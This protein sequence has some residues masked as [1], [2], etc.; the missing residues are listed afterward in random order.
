MTDTI[1]TMMHVMYRVRKT[2]QRERRVYQRAL[3]VRVGL[4][5]GLTE[6][7]FANCVGLLATHGWLTIDQGDRGKPI[8]IFNDQYANVSVRPPEEVI[9]HAEQCPPITE[10]LLTGA[11]TK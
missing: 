8:L 1:L 6:E 10:E 9:A 7:D 11:K 5:E 2:L 3:F 4:P